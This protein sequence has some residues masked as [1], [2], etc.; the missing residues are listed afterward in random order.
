MARFQLPIES[1]EIGYHFGGSEGA[2]IG[3]CN[4]GCVGK[5]ADPLACNADDEEAE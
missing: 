1:A 4:D 5:A 2:Q 3:Y